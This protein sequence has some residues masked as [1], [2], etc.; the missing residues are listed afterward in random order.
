MDR[1]LL[2]SRHTLGRPAGW[3][4]ALLLLAAA[5]TPASAQAPGR[6]DWDWNPIVF[7]GG[8]PV[9]GRMHLTLRS[10]G[11]YTFEGHFRNSG[12]PSYNVAVVYIVKDADNR[13]YT[14]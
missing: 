9:G 7:R 8:V 4:L 2:A 10:D 5:A 13:V 6:L 11:S 12:F 3:G 1:L 14:F